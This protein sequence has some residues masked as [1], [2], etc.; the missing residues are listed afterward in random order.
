MEEVR[1]WRKESNHG[2][3]QE[4]M[5]TS[6]L[7]TN[8]TLIFSTVAWIQET[9]TWQAWISLGSVLAWSNRGAGRTHSG[10]SIHRRIVMGGLLFFQWRLLLSWTTTLASWIKILA[11]ITQKVRSDQFMSQTDLVSLSST[12][13]PTT[14]KWNNQRKSQRIRGATISPTMSL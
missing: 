13:G 12:F 14:T 11:S 8:A 6:V 5:P 4:P 10:P 9:M 1:I 7:M 2:N 3:A